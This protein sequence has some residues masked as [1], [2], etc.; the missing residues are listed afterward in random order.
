MPGTSTPAVERGDTHPSL[1]L[2][3]LLRG[4]P[5]DRKIS[6]LDL[7][8]AS[9]ANI[10]FFSHC[11]LYV[12]DLFRTLRERSGLPAQQALPF[13][14]D[15]NSLLPEGCFDII[16]CWDLLNY[17]SSSQMQILGQHL[18]SR[19][20]PGCRIFAFIA[21]HGQIPDLPR[22][23]EVLAA[24][25]IRYVDGPAS[26]RKAPGYREPELNQWIAPFSVE[27]SFLLRHGMQ[28]YILVH[29]A[30]SANATATN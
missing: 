10:A 18:A 17:L 15:L 25:E 29:T 19:S 11:S 1:A 27:S 3:E 5:T 28:E 30:T 7:G 22:R 6:V 16:L 12:A 13:D 2:K 24:D 4:I 9:S 8:S 14:R 21:P 20:R 23:Y 26:L